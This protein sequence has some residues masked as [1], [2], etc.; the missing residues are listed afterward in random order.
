MKGGKRFGGEEE[1][2]GAKMGFH[3]CVRIEGEMGTDHPF[4]S[5]YRLWC[6]CSPKKRKESCKFKE[7]GKVQIVVNA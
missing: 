5:I 2:E 6:K 1:V 3:L 4:V 7:K